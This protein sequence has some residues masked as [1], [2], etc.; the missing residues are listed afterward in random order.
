[1]EDRASTPVSVLRV[2]CALQMLSVC[3]ASSLV[4]LVLHVSVV[5]CCWTAPLV[6]TTARLAA[7]MAA[8]TYDDF[9]VY[10]CF[11]VRVCASVW[12]KMVCRMLCAHH[13]Y[14]I[15]R[16]TAETLA[17]WW[18]WWWWWWSWSHTT[19]IQSPA[20]ARL[21]DHSY[22]H[23]KGATLFKQSFEEALSQYTRSLP[24]IARRS[25]SLRPSLCLSVPL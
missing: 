5:C 17:R 25:L 9:S 8:L 13:N 21:H 12:V 16:Y 2:H 18:W 15:I 4:C 7:S 11:S 14:G 6:H 3:L 19:V 23:S 20:E 1:M 24:S 22:Q 10:L